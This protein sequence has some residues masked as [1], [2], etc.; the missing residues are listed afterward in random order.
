MDQTT[1]FKQGELGVG[2]LI[3]GPVFHPGASLPPAPDLFR[4]HTQVKTLLSAFWDFCP[5]GRKSHGSGLT[6]QGCTVQLYWARIAL[7]LDPGRREHASHVCGGVN[8]PCQ[9]PSARGRNGDASVPPT[10]QLSQTQAAWLQSGGIWKANRPEVVASPL[11]PDSGRT[12]SPAGLH[13]CS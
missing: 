6:A 12:L 3:L 1:T 10:P 11:L 13:L 7:T 5:A 2:Y 8:A 4:G 9:V